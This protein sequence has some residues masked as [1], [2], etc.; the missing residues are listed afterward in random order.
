M[1]LRFLKLRLFKLFI[2]I[3][4]RHIIN[5]YVIDSPNKTLVI[6]IFLYTDDA[7]FGVS[8]TT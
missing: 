8:F 5:Y 6:F 7:H 3:I 2:K 4:I 1:Y